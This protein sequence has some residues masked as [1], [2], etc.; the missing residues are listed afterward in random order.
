ME[1]SASESLPPQK[2]SGSGLWI[3]A[4]LVLAAVA[5]GLGWWFLGDRQASEAELAAKAELTTLGALPAMDAERIHV[6]SINLSTLRSP[7]SL[8]RALALLADLPYLKSLNVE[9]TQFGDEH[10]GMVGELDSLES[11]VLSNTPI[12]DAALEKLAGL[13]NLA[14]LHLVDTGVT[15]AGM[16]AL[17]KIRSVQILN[18]SGTKVT[19]N[20]APL[21]ELPDLQ[22]LL[23][24]NL[25]LDAAA[26]AAIADFPAITRLALRGS[27]YPAEALAQLKQ[28][29]SGLAIDE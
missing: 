19:G 27:T 20:L 29:K 6:N 1:N 17:S 21:R 11:L 25:T 4:A 24:E 23:L 16:P 28:K 9:N 14:T 26:L 15:N 22:H 10:A 2:R 12:T 13:S 18:L 5:G 7:D 3:A 8:G